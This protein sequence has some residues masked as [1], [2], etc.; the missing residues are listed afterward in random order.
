MK[1]KKIILIILSILPLIVLAQPNTEVVL[2][3]LNAKNGT[4][5][6]SNFKNIS[7]NEGYD[8][9]PSFLDDRYV[10]FA[11]TRNG[12]TDIVKYHMDYDSKSWVNFSQGGEYSPLKIPNKN[13]VSAVRLD[14]D[15]KQR[16]YT[17]SLSNGESIELIADLVVAYYT[18]YDEQTIVSAI[19][20]G[21]GLNL[22]VTNLNDGISKKYATNVGR[23]F[24]KIPNT[25]L[26]SFISKEDENNWQIKSINPKTGVIKVIANTMQGVEDI[27]WVGINT[28][29]SGK[30]NV[31]Y[32]LTL[33]KDNNWREVANLKSNGIN[34]ITRLAT[35]PESNK[36]L[37]AGD[38]ETIISKPE[39][40]E[41]SEDI[42]QENNTTKPEAAEELVQQMMEAYNKR[43]IDKYMSFYS[44][45]VKLY[46]YPNELSTD[47]S[48][49]MRE[50]YTEFFKN[51]PDLNGY[52]KS[53]IVRGNKV[54]DDAQVT[55]NGEILNAI[56]IYEIENNKIIRVTFIY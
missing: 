49:A 44:D 27:C 50:S 18:W 25:N 38:V 24:H 55:I 6:L 52:A 41:K 22:F 9:Q 40:K 48:K 7:N 51:T 11:S 8:N 31:L 3:D 39:T 16:L 53:R 13:E 23:S 37:I 34:K 47:G 17:Y 14:T 21:D 46:N 45:D 26:V 36:L 56:A 28:I 2:F 10:L 29:L 20:E 32:K 12:Q 33:Q 15:G 4:Y 30:E 5:E 54:I 19:I 42:T 35:N 43:D 1:M